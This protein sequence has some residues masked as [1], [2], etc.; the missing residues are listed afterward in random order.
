METIEGG[1]RLWVIVDL[2]IL[3]SILKHGIIVTLVMG[4]FAFP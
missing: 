2:I 3:I 1:N 4:R